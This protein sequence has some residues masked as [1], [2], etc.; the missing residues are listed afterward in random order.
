MFA[1][2]IYDDG[3]VLWCTEITTKSMSVRKIQI[4]WKWRWLCVYIYREVEE[5]IWFGLMLRHGKMWSVNPRSQ[6]SDP[7]CRGWT[8]KTTWK[9]REKTGNFT[10]TL[11]VFVI[12][13]G[14][15]FIS[16]IF[17]FCIL[18]FEFLKKKCVCE[19][20]TL[21]FNY[22]KSIWNTL[23]YCKYLFYFK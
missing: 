18:Y 10:Q 8:T 23:L 19:I 16:I 5:Y 22:Q 3:F 15:T 4:M 1:W 17:F 21:Y 9:D 7:W 12:L 2:H 13:F 20:R 6:S 14:N 11:E